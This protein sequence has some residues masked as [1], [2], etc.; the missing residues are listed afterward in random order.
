MLAGNAAAEKEYE[1]LAAQI[2]DTEQ[3][4]NNYLNKLVL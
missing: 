3:Y 1:H 2:Q 4:L